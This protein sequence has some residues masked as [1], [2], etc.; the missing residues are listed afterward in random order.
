MS[1]VSNVQKRAKTVQEQNKSIETP[2][3][4]STDLMSAGGVAIV[5]AATFVG[6]E[7]VEPAKD[8]LGSVFEALQIMHD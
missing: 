8:L 1:C 3:S 6:I 5:L 7:H 4:V 2:R